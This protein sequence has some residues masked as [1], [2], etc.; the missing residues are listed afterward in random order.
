M[1]TVE[2][3]HLAGVAKLADASGLGPGVER[4]AGSIP[5]TRTKFVTSVNALQVG[6]AAWSIRAIA[7]GLLT[8]SVRLGT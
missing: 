8:D 6:S 3:Q 7:N 1:A 2:L 4:R 5:V